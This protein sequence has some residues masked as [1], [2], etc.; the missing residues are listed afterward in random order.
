MPESTAEVRSTPVPTSG[1]S[2]D[3]GNTSGTLTWTPSLGQAGSYSV[4]VTAQNLLSGSA[5]TAITVTNVDRAP[6]VTAPAT[7]S[8]SENA[9][10]T[11]AVTASDPDGDAISS[12]TATGTAITAGASFTADPG[13]TSG[14][15]SWTPSFTQAGSY[16]VTFTAQNL[17]SGS[18][19]TAITVTTPNVPPTA[20]ITLTPA[21]G[22]APL[23]VTANASGSTDSDGNI[24]FYRFDFG[25]GTIVGPQVSALASHSYTAGTWTASVLVTDNGGGIA[26][27][28]ATA[29][30]DTVGSGTNLVGNPSFESSTTGWGGQDGGTISRVAGGFDAGFAVQVVGAATT[31]K[32]GLNDS[33]NWVALTPSVGTTYLLSAWVQ[34]STAVGLAQIRVREYLAGVQRGSTILSTGVV[35]SPTWKKVTLTYVAVAAGSTIDV[36]VLDTPVSVSEVFRVDNIAIRIGTGGAAAASVNPARTEISPRVSLAAIVSPIPFNP[37][38]SIAFTTNVDGPV[39]MRVYDASGRFVRSL[40]DRLNTPAG[41]HTVRFDGR[42]ANGASL[43]SGIYF[44]RLEAREGSTSGRLVLVR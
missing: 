9:L 14:T 30:V 31:A 22:N 44:Y 37:E 23:V 38:A 19:T 41:F 17:L 1:F 21:T 34:S 3:P 26:S 15:L 28:S 32:F 11:F 12:L 29:I 5:T 18:A 20:A 7:S 42:N 4:T 24:V 33:P 27:A 39:R 2:A 36:Q 35:L 8:G 40:L 25:D 13:N 6:V 43:P 16:S 10:I